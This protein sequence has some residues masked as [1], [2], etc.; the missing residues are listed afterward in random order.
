MAPSVSI[1]GIVGRVKELLA[2][3]LDGV[4]PGDIREDLP[5]FDVEP[6]D[7]GLG[8]DSLDSLK[9]LVA[10]ANEYDLDPALEI[11]YSRVRTVRQ[12]AEYVHELLTAGG[13]ST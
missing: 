2:E 10:L 12:I 13:E 9:L 1:E 11:D 7:D 3:M 5:L 4:A 6:W 8:L